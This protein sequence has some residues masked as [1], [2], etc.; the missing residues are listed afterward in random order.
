MGRRAKQFFGV[1]WDA[2][3]TRP[4]EEVRAMLRVE[5]SLPLAA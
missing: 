4:L 1:D 5:E 2:Y 3:W